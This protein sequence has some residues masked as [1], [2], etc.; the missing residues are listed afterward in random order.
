MGCKRGRKP[1]KDNENYR[2]GPK[3]QALR[4]GESYRED[5]ELYY[6]QYLDSLNRKRVIY[7][8][9]LMALRK[10]EAEV[11]KD[12]VDNIRTYEAAHMTINDGFE[13]Y[14]SIKNEAKHKAV[15]KLQEGERFF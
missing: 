5:K 1:R 12:L 8:K 15:K 9:D 2:K 11:N 7:R 6:F 13:R 14:M 4:K 3:G 10:I